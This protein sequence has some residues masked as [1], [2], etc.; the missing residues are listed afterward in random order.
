MTLATQ[1]RSLQDRLRGSWR[2]LLKEVTAFGFV[3]ALAFLV[4]LGVFNLLLSHGTL[5]AKCVSTVISTAVAYFGNKHLSFSH[6][7]RTGIGRETSLFFG[8]NLFWLLVSE[9]VLAVFDYPLGFRNDTFVL[10][11][12]NFVT[13]VFGTVFRFWSYKRFVFLHPDRVHDPRADLEEEL[14]K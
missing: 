3:G 1:A 6:R 4:D 9:A 12:V 11:I 10:N 5:K 14:A 7:A 2:V 13:I 8:I